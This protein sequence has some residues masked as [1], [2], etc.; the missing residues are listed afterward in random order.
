MRFVP[1]LLIAALLASGC[2][3]DSSTPTAA[4]PTVATGTWSGHLSNYPGGGG[5]IVMTLNDVSGVITGTADWGG[6]YSIAGTHG[7]STITFQ[8]SSTQVPGE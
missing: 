2:N 7:D 5:V 4:T 3:K 1:A 8:A 6:P